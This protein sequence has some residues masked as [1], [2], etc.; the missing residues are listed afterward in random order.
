MKVL[1]ARYTPDKFLVAISSFYPVMRTA[2][3]IL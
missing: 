3:G 1:P 2:G